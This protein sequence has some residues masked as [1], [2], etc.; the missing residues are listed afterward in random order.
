MMQPAVEGQVATQLNND[1]SET[2]ICATSSAGISFGRAV[3]EGSN[4]RECV[5]GGDD[6]VGISYCDKTLVNVY[7]DLHRFGNNVG[8]MLA[9]DIWVR[10]VAAVMHGAIASYD[11]ITG[12]L[13]PASSGIEL[14]GS[15]YMTSAGAGQLALLRLVG[16]AEDGEGEAVSEW[17]PEGAAIH[18][19][20]VGGDPQG[21]AWVEGTGEVAVDTLLGS[22]ANASSAI[23][24]TEYN[25]AYLTVDGYVVP[26]DSTPE[27]AF[28][29]AARTTVMDS[30]TL[31][32]KF[33]QILAGPLGTI[34]VNLM[35][36]NGDDGL[37]V[38]IRMASTRKGII[39]S[40]NGD[41]TGELANLANNTIGTY[42]IGAVT[43]TPTRLEF[44]MNGGVAIAGTV[45]EIDR[46][47]GNPLVAAVVD[48]NLSVALQS[49]TLYDPLPS[50][51][52][53]SELSEA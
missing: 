35:S 45:E 47:S 10:V 37:F 39:G 21:R 23:G 5:L 48:T 24:T 15:R 32:V 6:F 50:T 42:N 30:A 51:D 25:S 8:I 11:A 46:P 7:G 33:K 26:L 41:L 4:A 19:D 1:N 9:G 40:Y 12:Q 2:R 20:L 52:G 16:K 27:P 18:I 38:D 53:L 3:S 43:V 34:A 13:N 44:A 49:I 29:G 28:I 31:V 14:Y 22:D 36:A 17:V